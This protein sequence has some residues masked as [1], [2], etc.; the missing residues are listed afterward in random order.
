MA[1]KPSEITLKIRK[2][3][4]I[5]RLRDKIAKAEASETARRERWQ[6]RLN[7]M[8]DELNELV[9]EETE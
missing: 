8:Q 5:E 4:K 7:E 1:R 6:L 3:A 2:I 9:V